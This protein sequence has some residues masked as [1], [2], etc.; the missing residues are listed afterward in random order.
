MIVCI[1]LAAFG[2]SVQWSLLLLYLS[3][4]KT[5]DKQFKLITLQKTQRHRRHFPCDDVACSTNR[6][7]N[8]LEY[9]K[10]IHLSVQFSCCQEGDPATMN[11]RTDKFS[12]VAP[13]CNIFQE[14]Y[15]THKSTLEQPTPQCYMVEMSNSKFHAYHTTPVL[16][17][18]LSCVPLSQHTKKHVHVRLGTA[19]IKAYFYDTAL[20]G[21]FVGWHIWRFQTT[22]TTTLWR[23]LI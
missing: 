9:I 17:K 3:Y 4:R 11:V 5:R 14:L 13:Y 1:P 6:R 20:R 18:L 21:C 22:E 16:L 15:W 19:N 2:W 8:I 7:S 12:P 10:P 23:S